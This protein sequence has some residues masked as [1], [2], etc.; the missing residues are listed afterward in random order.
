MKRFLSTLTAGAVVLVFGATLVFAGTPQTQT[1]SAPAS[2]TPA[3]SSTSSHS[4]KSTTA[5]S[6]TSTTSSSTTAAKSSSAT[7]S[8]ASKSSST[9][10]P[11]TLV[12]LNS[13]SKEELMKLPGIGDKISDKI[14]AGRPWANKSQLVSKGVVNQATYNKI[15]KLVIAKQAPAADKGA[16]TKPATTGK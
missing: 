3:K 6:S 14:I 8:T 12:D 15:S 5:T 9:A 11:A 2:T 16:A 4:S 1:G 13:A 7:G 10:A